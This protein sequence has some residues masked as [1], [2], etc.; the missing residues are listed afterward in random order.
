MAIYV[1]GRRNRHGRKLGGGKRSAVAA[2]NMTAMVDMF[3]VL[4][5]FLLQNYAT[6]NQVLPMPE[7]VELPSAHEV[8]ELKPSNVVVVAPDGI[9]INNIKVAEFAAVKEQQDW[10]ITNLK[11]VLEKSIQEGELKKKSV[12]NQVRDAVNEAKQVQP[13]AEVDEFRKVTIQSDKNIDFLTVKKVMYT[14]TE[15][16]MQEINFAV[17]KKDEAAAG[18]SM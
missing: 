4:C 11:D 6:T 14:V 5:V 12:T 18:Q 3:T 15:A 7:K 8:K 10:M 16:G 2:L 13:V 17:L 9:T 1:P